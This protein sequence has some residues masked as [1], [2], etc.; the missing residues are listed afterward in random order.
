MDK[1]IVDHKQKIIQVYDLKC[2]WAVENFYEEYYL[3]RRAY[4]QAFL[5]WK[6]VVHLKNEMGIGDYTVMEPR[7]IVCD[8]TNYYS[9]LIYA[10]S[11]EDLLDAYEGFEHKGKKYTGVREIIEDLKW[12][13]E[14]NLWEISR[15][16]YQN[17]GLVKL[18]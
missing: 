16:N 5:Y 1:V 13:V 10:L 2:V 8:S 9:P 7:F 3:Y 18:K 4:I 12:A 11:M 17:S 15:K 6:A 14:N